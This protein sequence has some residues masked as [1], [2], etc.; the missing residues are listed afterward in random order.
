MKIKIS[1]LKIGKVLI[2]FIPL[3][4][5][6]LLY[7]GYRSERLVM[8]EWGKTL[9]LSD[10]IMNW[11]SFCFHNSLPDWTTQALPDGL[12]LFSY[13]LLVDFVWE[14]EK[15]GQY[16]TWLYILPVITLISEVA[17]LCLPYLGT[18]DFMDLV[19]YLGAILLFKFKVYLEWKR[20]RI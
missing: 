18:F 7:L 9:G 17:Q 8:F 1:W 10:V 12:W 15:R 6:G 16:K 14:T 4:I 5:G 19:C 11:R 2:A 20:K 3:I 13:I